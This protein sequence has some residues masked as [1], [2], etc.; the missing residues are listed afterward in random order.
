M[1]VV[2][3]C[4]ICVYAHLSVSAAFVD[5]ASVLNLCVGLRG[6]LIR[7]VALLS[8]VLCV[9]VLCVGLRIDCIC[10]CLFARGWLV[11]ILVGWCVAVVLIGWLPG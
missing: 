10:A 7:W 1:C 3:Q 5:V 4:A 2:L 8:H 6:V 11:G 9:C